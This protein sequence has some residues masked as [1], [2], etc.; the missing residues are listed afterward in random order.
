MSFKLPPLPTFII[1]PKTLHGL[2]C[3]REYFYSLCKHWLIILMQ[4]GYGEASGWEL[5]DSLKTIT[6]TIS[7]VYQVGRSFDS[8]A[9]KGLQLENRPQQCAYTQEASPHT[10]MGEIS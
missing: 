9:F 1:V 4:R 3:Y 10:D 5:R 2:I 7:H 8:P 6:N